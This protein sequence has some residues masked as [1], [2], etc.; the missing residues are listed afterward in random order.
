MSIAM[1]LSPRERGE[2]TQAMCREVEE[3][4]SDRESLRWALGCLQA[5]CHER[6]KSIRPTESWGVRWGMAL[7]I[8]LLA[9]DTLFYA[10]I[11]LTY[12]LGLYTEHYPYPQNVPLIDVTPLWEPMLALMAGVVF[13]LAIV[14]ILRRSRVALGAV[15]APF[16]VTLLLFAVRFSRPESGY[17][18]SLS[19]AYQKS[20]FALIWPIVGLAI[21]ILI[22]LALWHD[23]H[24]P[25]PR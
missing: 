6:L 10:G 9:I 8:S 25:V 12:K 21:T 17:L 4:P 15:V 19:T 7:W 23:R 1:Q 3:I 14:L 2:W 20:H 18:Q 16:I 24:T 22:C 13:L 5:S 11:T